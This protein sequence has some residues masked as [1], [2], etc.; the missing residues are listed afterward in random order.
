MT[1]Y[2]DSM[3]RILDGSITETFKTWDGSNFSFENVKFE[4]YGTRVRKYNKKYIYL[5]ASK[6]KKINNK[7]LRNREQTHIY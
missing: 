7:E 2:W 6:I 5:K 3:Q 4:L 1:S